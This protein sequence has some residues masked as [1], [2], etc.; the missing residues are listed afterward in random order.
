[1]LLINTDNEGVIIECIGN[2]KAYTGSGIE[3]GDVVT[4]I[5][6]PLTGIIPLEKETLHLKKIHISSE[7]IADIHI[8][9]E[10]GNYWIILVDQTSEVERLRSLIQN[11]N[12][13]ELKKDRKD[14]VNY[15]EYYYIIDFAVFKRIGEE[16]FTLLE[17]VPGWIKDHKLFDKEKNSINL[18]EAFPFLEV[19]ILEAKSFW[20]E[21]KD[22]YL[23]SDMWSEEV[24]NNLFHLRAFAVNFEK[25]SYLLVKSFNK[26]GKEE[27][28]L[29]QAYRDS[30][31]AFDKLAK[32]ERKL[33]H[34]LEYK[35]K[36]NS[37]ISHD[38]RSP[39]ASVLG[40]MDVILNDRE[41]LNK[42]NDIYIEM[43]NDVKDEMIRLLDYNDKLYHW[44]N[45]ELGN[46][47]LEPADVALKDVLR[48]AYKTYVKAC[49]KK[50]ITLEKESEDHVL[51]RID[52]VLFLQALNNLLSNAVK[53]TPSGKK[54]FLRGY[55]KDD[56]VY[57][58]VKD[59]GVGI[60]KGTIDKLFKKDTIT[61]T[62]GTSG[63]K[64]TGLGMDIV[65]KIM[66]AHGFRLSVESEPGKGTKFVIEIPEKNVFKTL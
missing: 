3:R 36:F 34:L 54:I 49:E 4:E 43:L 57:V 18:L 60:S 28:K 58:E 13:R 31:L 45:L 56:K 32:T 64:G 37:I 39:I 44:A 30:S 62:P 38:L 1:L 63:E 21:K 40:V 7:V 19:F 8:V 65:K 20:D 33:K 26:E 42:L 9:K 6:T 5:F 48:S 12:E 35:N 10:N 16:T 11:M 46:F 24:G 50:N 22:G 2:V 52:E 17:K 47:K 61:S 15:F 59:E 14:K 51:I 25:E 55:E 41:Q 66:D 53:F 23:V 29:V 27:Q